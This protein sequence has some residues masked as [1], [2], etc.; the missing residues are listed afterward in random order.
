MSVQLVLGSSGAG[1]SHFIFSNIINDA[2]EHPKNH[3]IVIVPEQFTMQT[4]KEIVSMHPM[5][6]TT[7]ID[8]VSFERLAYRV[9][10]ELNFIPKDVL[11][12]VGKSMVIRKIVEENKDNL[13]V[14]SGSIHKPGFIEEVK[15]LLSEFYQYQIGED[16][17]TAILTK[18]RPDTMLYGKLS[19]MQVVLGG[20]EEFMEGHFIAAEQLLF[21]LAQKIVESDVMK[22]S[23]I[24]IDGFTGFTPIQYNLL[25]ELFQ[26]TSKVMIT[27]TI[28]PKIYNQ[29]VTKDY[30]LFALSKRTI[31]KIKDT[32]KE[33]DIPMLD[34]VLL[35]DTVPYRFLENV[36]L[37]HLEQTLFRFPYKSYPCEVENI[38]IN[39]AQNPKE[40]VRFVAR[41]IHSLV[42]GKQLRYRD[43]AVVTGAMDSYS[44]FLIE[45]FKRLNIPCFVDNK[46]S[47][48]NNPCIESLRAVL[49][50]IRS[51]FSY[52]QVFRYLK[53]GMT[54]LDP[55]D[56][57][58]LENY[59]IATG[60]RG[61]SKWKKPF[62]R[63]LRKLS[64]ARLEWLNEQRTEFM[65]E[66]STLRTSLKQKK[67]PVL[68]W[69]KAIVTFMQE[70]QFQDKMEKMRLKFEADGEFV[71]AKAYSQVYAGVLTL[72]DKIAEILGSE[73]MPLDELIGILDVG[74][75]ETTLGVIPPGLDQ[76]VV[77]DIE[78]TRL[79]DIKVLFFIGV[80]DGIIPKGDSG[81]G[82]M[83]DM[84]R[85]I[86]LNA[87]IEL[88]P[89]SKQSTFI[90]QFY[91]YL[92]LTKPSQEL[93]LSLSKVDNKAKSLRPSYLIGRMQKLF[94]ALIVT[95]DKEEEELHNLYT[96]ADSVEY[97]IEG[98]HR[99]LEGEDNPL[100]K[101]LFALFLEDTKTRQL[102]T[103]IVGGAFYENQESPLSMG[104]ARALYGNKL[105]NSVTRLEKYAACAF[106]HFLRYGL[107][108]E[109]RQ[110]HTVRSMDMGNVF[111]RA[112]EIFSKELESSE[113]DWNTIEDE[114][115]DQLVSTC[116]CTAVEEYNSELFNSSARNS[117]IITTM[118]RI[119][120]RTIW[121]LQEHIKRGNFEPTDF[122]LSFQN[123][124]GIKSTNVE[125][126]DGVTMSL[127]GKIDRI[128]TYEDEEHI[129]LKVI[130]YKSG[131]TMFNI[132][133]MYYGLQ[134][135]LMVYMNTALEIS[136][137]KAGGKI[138]IPAGIFY[139][140]MKDP[141]VEFDSDDDAR[142]AL[143]KEL[144]MNGLANDS[145]DILDQ[146]EEGD[147]RFI[148]IPV[149]PLKKGG[150][151]KAS[152]VAS[153]QQF[154]E[155]SEFVCD[156]ISSLGN[157]IMEGNIAIE[158]YH[159]GTKTA[160]DYCEYKAVCNFDPKI[161]PNAYKKLNEYDKEEI[162]NRIHDE[163]GKGEE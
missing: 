70:L 15:S 55:D 139:Y 108:L 91:L 80:N 43:I 92:N 124:K 81:G 39:I 132:V 33:V 83:T 57:D 118:E 73:I 111:H 88:A 72:F 27:V 120:K 42:S 14:F 36:E 12:D 109:P 104:I 135:Q 8:I 110:E 107:M 143:L 44:D 26:S 18:I 94:P 157:E 77:G 21:V 105:N 140:N 11:E 117:Y 97:L 131:N 1:K 63:N 60:I 100:W 125:L 144:K 121:A 69:L 115:R 51:D 146:L 10:D 67:A 130:D 46:K 138:V 156:K 35:D 5:H 86:L 142:M 127:N 87:Q 159:L 78:R 98:L 152:K 84:D 49:E 162:W 7:N 114:P 61:Y 52:E 154:M 129:Y 76:I 66:V 56:I 74:L 99:Y 17:L 160:C 150:F 102:L 13:Q 68:E 37:F 53:T 25:G 136:K 163:Y 28:D 9:F 6:G 58:S 79:K 64:E 119:A 151:S 31:E 65:L 45:G 106:A 40:E 59:I 29:K 23:V 126:N 103:T 48:L 38:H 16:E 153:T 71:M 32:A 149:T 19:D 101:E 89:T 112:I 34:S 141:L 95:E 24:C 3:Y 93:Y 147:D 54:S 145:E 85:E 128:D 90:E 62:T 47:I 137:K 75:S 148:S 41:R 113:F 123:Y 134:I 2:I 158:P 82:I 155:I 20:F 22:D 30:E 122:E 133:D 50:M 4:Q 116:V 161:T 96:R